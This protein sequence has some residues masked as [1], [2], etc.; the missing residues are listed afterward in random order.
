MFISIGE[1]ISEKYPD[2]EFQLSDQCFE[3]LTTLKKDPDR[4]GYAIPDPDSMLTK[5]QFDE[6]VAYALAHPDRQTGNIVVRSH[7]SSDPKCVE[8]KCP[9]PGWRHCRVT[10]GS[11]DD[12]GG[13]PGYKAIA[14]QLDQIWHHIDDGGTLDKNCQWYKD[15]KSVKT[16][17]AKGSR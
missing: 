9:D 11:E 7:L 13:A 3:G 6:C 17:F 8:T 10:S 12:D 16:T 5:A 2:L 4:P 14:E 1:A 15:V